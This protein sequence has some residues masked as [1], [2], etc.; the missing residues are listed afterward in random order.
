M[1]AVFAFVASAL[2]S[3]TAGAT[4]FALEWNA[5]RNAVVPC[6]VEVQTNKLA[7]AGIPPKSAFVVSA[8]TQDGVR[9]LKTTLL[10]GRSVGGVFLRFAAP[11]GTTG[12]LCRAEGNATFADPNRTDNLLAGALDDAAAWNAI[13]NHLVSRPADGDGLVFAAKSF[14]GRGEGGPKATFAAAVPP[15]MRGLPVRFEADVETDSEYSFCQILVVRQF[16]ASGKRL[17]ESVVDPRW[18]GLMMPAKWRGRFVET[19]RLH[20]EAAT[21]QVELSLVASELNFV[22]EERR[23]NAHGL[24]FGRLTATPRLRLRALALRPAATL[25]SIRA[26]SSTATTTATSRRRPTSRQCAVRSGRRR[27]FARARRFR[28]TAPTT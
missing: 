19:G 27:L 14:E 12:L 17:P 26:S 10:P 23:H 25:P 16:D 6:E 9:D 11:P 22:A 7:A 28:S 3:A 18:T 20:P 8:L 21:V 5:R 15:A 1:D 2:L 4:S 24:P 13:P